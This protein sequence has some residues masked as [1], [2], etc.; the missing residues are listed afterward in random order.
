MH[1]LAQ[2][3]RK[4][5]LIQTKFDPL[6]VGE[7]FI[8]R[9]RLL[10]SIL[11]PN[12][13]AQ[14]ITIVGAAGS[15]KSILM[16]HLIGE[17]QKNRATCW[18]SLDED[19]NN[20]NSFF[21]YFTAALEELAPALGRRAFGMISA[22]LSHTLEDAFQSLCEDISKT[23]DPIALFFD[24]FQCI[25]LP[26][27]IAGLNR[28]IASL[29][30]NVAVILASRAD[31]KL[32]LSKR[33]LD[34]TLTEI[35]QDEINFSA[36]EAAELL[37]KMHDISMDEVDVE[38][39]TIS[40]E[41]WATGIQLA[42]MA[43]KKSGKNK[44][45]VVERFSGADKTL[46]TYLLETV[47]NSQPADVRTFLMRTA[48]LSRMSVDLCAAVCE[49]IDCAQMLEHLQNENMF[50]IPLDSDGVWFRYHHLFTDFLMGQLKRHHEGA[51][52]SISYTASEW[53]AQ[54]GLN[55]E[56]IKYLLAA[57]RYRQA[58][59]FIAAEG[60]E[61][62][63][64]HGDHHLIL[65]WMRLLPEKYHSLHPQILLNFAWAHVFTR[66]SKTAYEIAER[67]R[68]D[69]EAKSGPGWDLPDELLKEARCLAD[70][71]QSI[72]LNA[73]DDTAQALDFSASK[74]KQWPQAHAIHKATL[75]NSLSLACIATLDFADG[76]RAASKG[77]VE[78]LK[79]NAHFLTLWADWL[80]AFICI[81]KGHLNEAEDYIRR[82]QEDV[83][84]LRGAHTYGDALIDVLKAQV[85]YD[86]AEPE[87]AKAEIE[88]SP[89]FSAIY[90]PLEPLF[91]CH[92]LQAQI[93][94]AGGFESSA[95]H[96]L[97]KGQEVGLVSNL[98][99]LS[100][101]LGAEEV[102]LLLRSG[103]IEAATH[104]AERWELTGKAD[105][106]K[107][108]FD[109]SLIVDREQ[110]ILAR[111]LIA[112]KK[113]G[114]ALSILLRLAQNAKVRHHGRAFTQCQILKA[115][116]LWHLDR[117]KAAMRELSTATQ[118]AAPHGLRGPFQEADPTLL[119]ILTK[120]V[121]LRTYEGV[122]HLKTTF[123]FERDLLASLMGSAGVLT[124]GKDTDDELELMD[125]LTSR[126]TEI[127]TLL[128]EGLGNQEIADTLLVALPTVKWH[129]HN[130]YEKL[131]VRRRTAA[132]S[133]A[134]RLKLIE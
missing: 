49:P 70:V 4:R 16:G 89:W 92:S 114:K 119:D 128:A 112:D 106:L 113:Y 102:K 50:L 21:A 116:A 65:E 62:A 93:Q 125:P 73:N 58:A 81:E 72:S 110:E 41:G 60:S 6:R 34:G 38:R 105:T 10:H 132:V 133:K 18:I 129:S 97:Q 74:L 127:L 84:N 87:K 107:R 47:F 115:T 56:A 94:F 29:P 32:E 75:H 108:N 88:N 12:A 28:F 24:D 44:S 77:R 104:V 100:I 124:V 134:R 76:L 51:F 63:Q 35:T 57:G 39:L 120:M 96:I 131:D 101:L 9:E 118:L 27:I 36:G 130:I 69:L 64:L 7:K 91:M 53:F 90:G 126:E 68:K 98:P 8:V 83:S 66:S 1:K 31:V 71:I 67:V 111:L 11:E 30:S 22:D 14:V 78:S 99:R 55:T 117:E 5:G 19:M 20:V 61:V 43:L 103:Q 85:L 40:T 109:R 33:R 79:C 95:L 26:E 13:S 86:R 46:N 122:G 45:K 82:G 59:D 54:A 121:S 37:R 17:M 15:G 25:D 42:G 52:E 48:P 23:S 80:S 2:N 3:S 123:E